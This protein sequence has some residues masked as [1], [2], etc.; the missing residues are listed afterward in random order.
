LRSRAVAAL[1]GFSAFAAAGCGTSGTVRNNGEIAVTG[2]A[3]NL[4]GPV[5]YAQVTLEHNGEALARTQA[6]GLGRFVLRVEPTAERNS[7]Q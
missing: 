2:R 7:R 4:S 5:K 3:L 1:V 6:D